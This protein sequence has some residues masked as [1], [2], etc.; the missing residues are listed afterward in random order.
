MNHRS[1]DFPHFKPI[2]PQLENT[3]LNQ[4]YGRSQ[5]GFSLIEIMVSVGILAIVTAGLG[6]M[7]ANTNREMQNLRQQSTEDSVRRFIIS[8]VSN[9][10]YLNATLIA[11]PAGTAFGNCVSPAPTLPGPPGQCTTRPKRDGGAVTDFGSPIAI[12][13]PGGA[14]ITGTAAAPLYYSTTNLACGAVGPSANC[15]IAVWTSFYTSCDGVNW[16]DGAACALGV[17]A[18]QIGIKYYILTYADGAHPATSAVKLECNDANNAVAPA[19]AG[20]TCGA[21]GAAVVNAITQIPFFGQ[22]GAVAGHAAVWSSTSVA[23]SSSV[24]LNDQQHSQ[25]VGTANGTITCGPN[26]AGMLQNVTT[27]IGTVAVP[28]WQPTG[29][30]QVCAQRS[31]AALGLP[32]GWGWVTI[33]SATGAAAA[34]AS[35]LTG[36]T[37]PA[38]GNIISLAKS[39]PIMPGLY[40]CPSISG[41]NASVCG[42]MAT[43][44][45]QIQA[46]SLCCTN[47]S[48]ATTC[49][50]PGAS[51]AACALTTAACTALF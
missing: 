9:P 12:L 30:I 15:P 40:L 31:N 50:G 8:A 45:G 27:N 6:S 1:V 48:L 35:G 10:L 21:A 39:L 51:G 41:A 7:M 23:G 14:A 29:A 22:T 32:G 18:A 19:P 25:A 3:V 13:A 33:T 16:N 5:S 34:T 49:W 43:C 11:N 2:L 26:Y 24:M 20:M 4:N 36:Q 44:H 42:G 38:A 17:P 28:V 46:S 37:A 47:A